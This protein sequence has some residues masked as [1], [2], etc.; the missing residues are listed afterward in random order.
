MALE[1]EGSDNLV[2]IHSDSQGTRLHRNLGI[3]CVTE[4]V[5]L[6]HKVLLH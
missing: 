2:W 6:V 3:N 1:S 4:L 5:R